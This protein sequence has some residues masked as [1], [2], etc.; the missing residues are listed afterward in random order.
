M[1][2]QAVTDGVTGTV[3]VNVMSSTGQ[4]ADGATVLYK[5]AT[6]TE[7]GYV[8]M[9]TVPVHAAISST[10][11]HDLTVRCCADEGAAEI[12]QA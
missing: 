3:G 9:P 8:D 10:D 7:S 2:T 4:I 1:T 5:G 6:T 11:L 12:T